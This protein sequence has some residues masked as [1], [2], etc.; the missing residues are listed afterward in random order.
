MIFQKSLQDPILLHGWADI[1][2]QLFQLLAAILHADT[3]PCRF[4]HFPV[5]HAVPDRNRVTEWDVQM[6]T[7]PFYCSALI[8]LPVYH[9]AVDEAMLIFTLD[10]E[11]KIRGQL[12]LRMDELLF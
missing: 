3:D 9:F 4:Q 7:Y 6:V 1:I 2:C 5:V 8:K 10:T 11:I 12:F